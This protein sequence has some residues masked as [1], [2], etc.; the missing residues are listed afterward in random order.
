MVQTEQAE[1]ARQLLGQAY[2]EL[3]SF[4]FQ[5]VSAEVR[6]RALIGA[7]VSAEQ[8]LRIINELRASRRFEARV[9]VEG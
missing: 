1:R 6:D 8:A 4:H 7:M 9:T 2:R 5:D 3:G